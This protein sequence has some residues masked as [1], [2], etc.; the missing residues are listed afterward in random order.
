MKMSNK[1]REDR[2]ESHI[3]LSPDLGVIDDLFV[4]LEEN[5]HFFISLLQTVTIDPGSSHKCSNIF[6]E[7]KLG[8]DPFC[9]EVHVLINNENQLMHE[10]ANHHRITWNVQDNQ[11]M[12]IGVAFATPFELRQFWLFHAV[13]HV[14]VTEDTNK[15]CLLYTSPSPRD[16]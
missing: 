13:V 10:I 8:K 2:G 5:G 14:Y 15:D 9:K 16:P 1:D 7:T 4:H 3:D 12:M 11:D 6:S